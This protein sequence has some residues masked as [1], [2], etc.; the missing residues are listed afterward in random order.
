MRAAV[1]QTRRVEGRSIPTQKGVN[2]NN[3]SKEQTFY[4]RAPASRGH[5]GEGHREGHRP[6][7]G[8][9]LRPLQVRRRAPHVRH[10]LQGRTTRRPA[11]WTTLISNAMMGDVELELL[12]PVDGNQALIETLDA[13]GEGLHHIGWLTTD[14]QGRH[15]EGHRR[16]LHGLDQF[17]RSR[18]A[19]VL[20]LRGLGHGQPGHRD[21]GSHRS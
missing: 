8:P 20:L 16:G 12:E 19:R 21:S 2:V 15:G 3:E 7:G 5:R 1:F 17:H 6:L 9:G 11:E 4:N 13:Q 14:L 10:R 18:A